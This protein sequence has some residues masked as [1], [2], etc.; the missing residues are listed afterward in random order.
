M[1]RLGQGAGIGRKLELAVAE[2]GKGQPCIALLRFC[3]VSYN[4]LSVSEITK[5]KMKLEQA[6][7]TSEFMPDQTDEPCGTDCHCFVAGSL[8]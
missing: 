4:T 6:K 1:K 3:G 5:G 8:C 7:L 2:L